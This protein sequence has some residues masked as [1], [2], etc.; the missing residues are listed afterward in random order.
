MRD[1]SIRQKYQGLLDEVVEKY[2][3]QTFICQFPVYQEFSLIGRSGSKI[4]V[5]DSIGRLGYWTLDNFLDESIEPARGQ[6]PH[7]PSTT[8]KR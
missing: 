4:A 5:R 6:W 1:E 2:R 7:I 3:D 8:N